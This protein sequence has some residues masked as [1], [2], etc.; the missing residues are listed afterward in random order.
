[1][2]TKVFFGLVFI[3]VSLFSLISS[4]FNNWADVGVNWFL[5]A[6][7]GKKRE[8]HKETINGVKLFN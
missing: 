1:M 6:Q 7:N 5:I 8:K 4:L 3:P 2:G